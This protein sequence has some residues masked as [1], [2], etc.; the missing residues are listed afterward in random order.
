MKIT[1][2]IENTKKTPV[3]CCEHGLSLLIEE[4]GRKL[5]LDAGSSEAFME[6]AKQM[7]IS[8][9]EIDVCVLSHGHYDHSTG[10]AGFLDRN[11][12]A[13]LYA[14]KS[15]GQEYYSGSG[16]SIHYIGLPQALLDRKDTRMRLLVDV[17]EIEPGIWVVPHSTEGLEVIG[18]QKKLYRKEGEQ[19]L[20]DDF[21]HEL[22]LVY[23]TE[24]GLVLFNSCSHGGI[25]N[26]ITEVKQALPGRKLYAFIGGLHMKGKKQEEEIC[27]FTGEEVKVMTAFLEKSGL[28]YLYTGHCTGETGLKMLEN[29]LGDKV[30]RMQTGDIIEIC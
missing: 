1:V 12:G 3:F 2:L 23:E 21:S 22:T 11:P 7:G 30:R 17:T 29:E 15:A 19:Y 10:F 25:E 4:K 20:P 26:I 27:T 13:P 8:L 9:Q 24:K 6:N 28:E 5:L 16:G 14:M 18:Q